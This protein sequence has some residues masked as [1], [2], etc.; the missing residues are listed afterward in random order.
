MDELHEKLS[1]TKTWSIDIDVL[2]G[3]LCQSITELAIEHA[4][5]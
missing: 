5:C 3:I 4:H 2:Q 1:S